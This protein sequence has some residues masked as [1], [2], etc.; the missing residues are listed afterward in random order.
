MDG[1][2]NYEF[3]N[4]SKGKCQYFMIIKKKIQVVTFQR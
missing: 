1:M 2:G 4:K 3:S